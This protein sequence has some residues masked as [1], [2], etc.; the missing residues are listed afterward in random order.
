MELRSPRIRASILVAELE[1][2]GSPRRKQIWRSNSK[3][4]P[5][6]AI[7]GSRR[8]W[9]GCNVAAAASREVLLP[10]PTSPVMTVVRLCAPPQ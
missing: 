4:L 10:E 8:C 1:A 6:V 7:R 5:V 2:A 3:R 9:V